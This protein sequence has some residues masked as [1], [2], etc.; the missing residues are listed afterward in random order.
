VAEGRQE[1]IRNLIKSKYNELGPASFNEKTILVLFTLLVLAWLFRDPKFI[2][3]WDS[4]F[5]K[6]GN[7]K[8]QKYNR[9]FSYLH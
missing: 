9:T 7:L 4:L 5:P 2:D 6:Y 1:R 3:G 8:I